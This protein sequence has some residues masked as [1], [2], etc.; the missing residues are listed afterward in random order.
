M[1]RSDVR[2]LGLTAL[3]IS[4]CLGFATA[5]QA[6]T[7]DSSPSLQPFSKLQQKASSSVLSPGKIRLGGST[8]LGLADGINAGTDLL[9]LLAGAPNLWVK[10]PVYSDA[11]QSLTLGL[12]AFTVSRA[13]LLWGAEK[14]SVA[15]LRYSAFHP[16]LIYTHRQSDRLLLHA[17]WEGGREWGHIQLSEKG[18]AEQARGGQ[19]TSFSHQSI[20]LQSL[21]GFSQE[22]F[23]V[24]GEWVRSPRETLVLSAHVARFRL[25]NLYAQRIGLQ[26]AQQWQGPSLG[27][28][29]GIGSLFQD[30]DGETLAG[31][32]VS[33][34]RILP[35]AECDIFLLLP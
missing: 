26:L 21:L 24:S 20:L 6:E 34:G 11:T 18:K 5:S 14:D 2:S 33:S 7:S 3:I 30:L 27:F 4:F 16:R 10:R 15:Q 23:E 29:L 1:S 19:A 13:S 32:R 8:A 31:E 9:P 28:R 25:E 17:V 35:T 12:E 22:R